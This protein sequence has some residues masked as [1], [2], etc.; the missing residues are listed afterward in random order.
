[1][2][3]PK[4]K[5]TPQQKIIQDLIINV[6]TRHKSNKLIF[7]SN[8]HFEVHPSSTNNTLQNIGQNNKIY[9]G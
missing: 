2:L 8:Y 6:T 3:S 5:K 7:V 4:S 9:L 1:V